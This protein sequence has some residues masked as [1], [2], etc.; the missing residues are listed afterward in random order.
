MKAPRL[1]QVLA[2]AAVSATLLLGHVPAASAVPKTQKYAGVKLADPGFVKTPPFRS[3]GGQGTT[4]YALY[5]TGDSGGIPVRYRAKTYRGTYSSSAG[6]YALPASALPAWV[7]TAP[8]L[9]RRLWAP[10]VFVRYSGESSYDYV[11]YFTAWHAKRGQNCIGTARSSSPFGSFKVVG[12]PICAPAKAAIKGDARKPEAIDPSSLQVGSTRYLMFKTSVANEGKWTVWAV[13]MDSTGTKRAKGA[14]PV[15]VKRFAGKAENP[16]IIKRGSTYWMF[17]SE[18]QYTTCNYRT[19]AYKS[20][21]LTGTWTKYT[22]SLLTQANTGLCGPG[23]ASVLPDGS[24]YRVAYHAWENPSSPN[25]GKRKT[26]VATLK[27]T[28]AGNPYVA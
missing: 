19:A 23:G 27:W 17:V 1:V 12:G 4:Y 16:D 7:G 25:T 15:K 10:D 11:M 13:K 20:T 14:V 21:S 5:G 9:G 3:G 24:A 2:V 26:Y 28:S 8:S 22:G 6:K 18:D